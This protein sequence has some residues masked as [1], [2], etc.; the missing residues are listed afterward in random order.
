MHAVEYVCVFARPARE[1]LVAAER[2]ARALPA[3]LGAIAA[4]CDVHHSTSTRFLAIVI[5]VADELDPPALARLA[6]W[7]ARTGGAAFLAD[8]LS[9]PAH[10]RFRAELA[11]CD[12]NVR[13]VPLDGL[14][15]AAAWIFRTVGSPPPAKGLPVLAVD[16]DGPG[17]EGLHYRPGDGTLFVAG[18]LAPP[19]GDALG[20]AVR[21]RGRAAPLEG[22]GSVTEV[23][24]RGAAGPG[25]PAGFRIRIELPPEL[26]EVLEAQV[27][28]TPRSQLQEAPRFSVIGRV[29]VKPIAVAAEGEGEGEGEVPLPPPEPPPPPAP[30]ATLEYATDAELE[31]DW[32]ENLSHGGAFVRSAAPRPEGTR[33]ALDL[34]L[35]DGVRLEAQAI[36][37]TST[38]KGMGVRFVLSQAQDD[39]LATAIARIS[40]RPR[41]ALVVDDDGLARAMI[42]DALHARGFEVITAGDASEGVERLS[43]ELM[44]LDL[45]VTDVCMP[46]MN[47][48]ELIRFIRRTG[49]ESELAIA[50]VT[51][52]VEPGLEERLVAA[53]ADVVLDKAGGAEGVAAAADAALE[54]KRAAAGG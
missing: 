15:E 3:F 27:A 51:G 40:A 47:G 36:V 19:L 24:E 37:M 8:D 14:P 50:A 32:I 26:R 53:G 52:R 45:L 5:R 9:G 49:G 1:R 33:L 13:R 22:T 23:V 35:P 34:A 54:R 38:A 29:K 21:L 18:V 7:A 41:R 43:E 31:A 2:L 42:S 17:R 44:A 46:G 48:E 4:E 25:R 10:Q 39:L 12:L 11:R 30:R 16:L 6:F 20:L 28:S